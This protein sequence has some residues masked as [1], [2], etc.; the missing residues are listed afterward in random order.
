MEL[1]LAE[2]PEPK[3]LQEEDPEGEG[4][5]FAWASASN[6]EDHLD[7]KL[8]RPASGVADHGSASPLLGVRHPLRDRDRG[9]IM[10]RFKVKTTL[11]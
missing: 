8:D 11:V 10:H 5:T 6:A 1:R 7:S 4:S 2:D 3:S 9:A